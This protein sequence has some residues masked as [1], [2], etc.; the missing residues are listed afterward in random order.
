MKKRGKYSIG[1]MKL[2]VVVIEK[3]GELKPLTIKEFKV[4]ELYKKCSF[5]TE[6]N[7]S[8]QGEWTLEEEENEDEEQDDEEQDKD[9]DE[10]KDEEKVFRYTVYGKKVGK[11]NSVNKYDFPPPLD[12]ELFYGN[13][14][15]VKCHKENGVLKY[16]DLSVEEW[17]KVYERLFGGFEEIG[18]EDSEDEEE[19][20]DEEGIE[21][22]KAGYEKDGF[23][24]DSSEEDSELN[25]EEYE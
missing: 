6:S 23:V 24:V 7:F 13:M 20:E 19:S 12:N 1:K 21:K 22:T 8:I 11:S 5:K 25:Y 3:S 2:D 18:S 16:V 9:D 17:E 10:D 4:E 14:V 15:V